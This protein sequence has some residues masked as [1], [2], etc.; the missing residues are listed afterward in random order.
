MQGAWVT[1]AIELCRERRAHRDRRSAADDAVGA[2]HSLID[3]GDVHRAALALAKP[4]AAAPDFLH[5]AVKVTALGQAMAMAAMG[6]N[7]LV[8]RVQVLANAH[9]HGF[10]AAVEVSETGDL[11][12]LYLAVQAFLEFPDHLHLAVGAQQR[13]AAQLHSLLPVIRPIPARTAR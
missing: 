7:D 4:F 8:G 5:H 3:V 9:G 6:R 11:A 2:E 10:L 1:T 13:L 12:G